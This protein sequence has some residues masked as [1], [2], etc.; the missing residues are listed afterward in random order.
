[1]LL[2]NQSSETLTG[3]RMLFAVEESAPSDDGSETE[4][5]STCTMLQ[6]SALYHSAPGVCPM[7]KEL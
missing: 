7:S 3:C 2:A 5:D 1:M 6:T 4:K